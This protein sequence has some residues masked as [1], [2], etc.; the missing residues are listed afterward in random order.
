MFAA[1]AILAVPF[2]PRQDKVALSFAFFG[3][4]RLDKK[5]AEAQLPTNPS[6]ANL[7]QLERTYADLAALSPI[8][9]L[10][11][12]GGDLVNNY[13]DDNGE[14]LIKQMTGWANHFKGSVLAGKT[15]MVPFPGNHELNKKLGDDRMQNP[16]TL[17]VWR[18]WYAASGF[19]QLGANGP[20]QG[21]DDDD[22][23]VG[24]QSTLNYSFTKSGVH[25][26][27]LSTDTLTSAVDEKTGRKRIGWIPLEWTRRDIEAAQAD[28]AV[29]AIFVLGHRNLISPDACKG[30]APIDPVVGAKL[31]TVLQTNL[32]V[33]AYI[34]AHVHAYDVK[35]LGGP[36]KAWQIVSGNGG[37]SLEKDW[38]PDGGTFFGF[39]VLDVFDSGK[40]VLRNFK[41]PTPAAPL[42]YFEGVPEPAK[43][44]E[45]VLYDPVK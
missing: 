21:V 34:C 43:P 4:N 1:L 19:P 6:S 14:T 29:K 44:L 7:P 15:T 45:T 22:A 25:F 26:V 39:V 40:V 2:Q 13:A 3:C 28:P 36:S 42:K 35:P 9:E 27:V 12:G 5:D 33:R 30:D 31:L 10:V 20:K 18:T 32:K 17:D 24:D 11:F 41:R 8:P 37:S 16:P 38:A 23:V